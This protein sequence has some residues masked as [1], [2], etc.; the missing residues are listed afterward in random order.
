[1]TS[2]MFH[3]DNRN[4]RNIYQIVGGRDCHIGCMFTET[5][6]RT[7]V[8]ALNAYFQGNAT[9]STVDHRSA[10]RDRRRMDATLSAEQ[11]WKSVACQ[12]LDLVSHQKCL[13][14]Q[15]SMN[16]GMGCLCDC[17]DGQA[18][19]SGDTKEIAC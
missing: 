1:V 11:R 2:W 4:A 8:A 9:V 16:D 6:G 5:G 10:E 19:S 7:V 15:A 3:N 13:G 17:H 18:P 14:P 12:Q